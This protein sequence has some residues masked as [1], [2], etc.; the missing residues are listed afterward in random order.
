MTTMRQLVLFF[1]L[2]VSQLFCAEEPTI[3]IT[4]GAGYIGSATTRF[5]LQQGYNVVVIDKK[6]PES[7]FFQRQPK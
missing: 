4:G 6:L 3:L 1:A 7:R 2:F 5:M